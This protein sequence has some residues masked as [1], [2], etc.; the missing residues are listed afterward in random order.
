MENTVQGAGYR[1]LVSVKIQIQ[2][3]SLGNRIQVSGKIQF[4]YQFPGASY[5]RKQIQFPVLG[6]G[7]R[8][9]KNSGT[10]LNYRGFGFL[11]PTSDFWPP[12]FSLRPPASDF[13]LL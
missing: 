9:Y 11:L 2:L 7:F 5:Q 12:V 8:E 13:R 3:N 6:T 10:I 1:F 4:G